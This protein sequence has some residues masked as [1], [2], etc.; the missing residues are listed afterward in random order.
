MRDKLN[1]VVQKLIFPML[2]AIM[3]QLFSM[4]SE[5]GALLAI[6]QRLE[7]LAIETNVEQAHRKA[8]IDWSRAHRKELE[9]NGHS[10]KHDK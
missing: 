6:V 3:I 7:P 1:D 5:I 8:I 2:V 4:K 9:G 10:H